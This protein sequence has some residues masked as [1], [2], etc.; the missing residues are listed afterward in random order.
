MIVKRRFEGS[1]APDLVLAAP[2]HAL[3]GARKSETTLSDAI[4]RR[5]V[6]VEGSKRTLRNFQAVFRPS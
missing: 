2:A 5:A 3:L 4:A 6:K 1:V